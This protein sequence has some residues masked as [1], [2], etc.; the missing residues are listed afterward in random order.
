L[1]ALEFVPEVQRSYLKIEERTEVWEED[2]ACTCHLEP[3]VPLEEH[4]PGC[5][6]VQ[7]YLIS[8]GL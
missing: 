4:D 1:S 6:L 3:S 7:A 2:I 8:R 5:M